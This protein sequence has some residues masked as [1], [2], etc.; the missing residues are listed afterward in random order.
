[1]GFEDVKLDGLSIES[2]KKEIDEC[3]E[4][5]FG[6]TSFGMNNSLKGQ[7][8]L[9]QQ[10]EKNFMQEQFRIFKEY[11]SKIGWDNSGNTMRANEAVYVDF[12]PE[13]QRLEFNNGTLK[14]IYSIQ[15][16]SV[17]KKNPHYH[18]DQNTAHRPV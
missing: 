13:K 18:V 10:A 6:K 2:L 12:D 4:K 14:K 7:Y 11:F 8:E 3:N 17:F 1:M 16:T 5:Y 9:Y 15:P